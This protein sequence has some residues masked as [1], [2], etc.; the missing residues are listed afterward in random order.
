[1]EIL[2]DVA[3][4][5]RVLVFDATVT[6]LHSKSAVVTEHPVESG[7]NV[8]DHKR[9]ERARLAA[10][11]HVTNTPIISPNVDGATGDVAPAELTAGPFN[12]I[13]RGAQ[14]S[15][16]GQATSSTLEPQTLTRTANVLQFL[17]EF[18]RVATIYEQL[19]LLVDSGILL[20]VV[21]SLRQY[22]NMTLM[23]L[24]VPRSA[25]TRYT[26]VFNLELV[27]IRIA[28]SQLVGTPEPLET[29]GERR[30]R[31]GAQGAEEQTAE[32]GE[33]RS[34]AAALLEDYAGI[35]LIH[36]PQRSGADIFTR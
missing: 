28:E 13:A 11:V 30:R 2:F 16:S 7:V 5:F 19:L 34:L 18:D 22:D 15:K 23:D 17:V 12:R 20:T 36:R 27:E 29:R 6:E 10:E 25:A 4:E 9:P 14:V 21:T 31:R 8:S 26:G 24:G 35:G 32:A 1:M 3:G 33:E